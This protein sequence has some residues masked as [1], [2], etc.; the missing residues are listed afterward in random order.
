MAKMKNPPHPGLMLKVMYLEPLGLNITET[1]EKLDMPRS[2][3]SEIVNAKRAISPEVAVKLEKAFPKHSASFW[4]RAQAGYALSR[5]NPHC[6]DK[7]KPIKT[8]PLMESV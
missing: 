3:L 8:S 7:V 2:A 5:V 6:A 4:L 1:A